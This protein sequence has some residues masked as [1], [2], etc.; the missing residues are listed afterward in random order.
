MEVA[1]IARR[2]TAA[3]TIPGR[4]RR[5]CARSTLLASFINMYISYLCARMRSLTVC[6]RVRARG[7]YSCRCAIDINMHVNIVR[8]MLGL[9]YKTPGRE[10]ITRGSSSS[11]PLCLFLVVLRDVRL[12]LARVVACVDLDH[13]YPYL[14]KSSGSIRVLNGKDSL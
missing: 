6:M 1:D 13:T 9:S 12:A 3:G 7:N 5:E 11:F 10:C 8:P 14:F 4:W 2:G